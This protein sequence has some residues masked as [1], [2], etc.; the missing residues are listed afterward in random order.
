[1]ALDQKQVDKYIEELLDEEKIKRKQQVYADI[2]AKYWGD[3][4][5]KAKV[6][7]DPTS[8]LKA[9]GYD[10]PEGAR[11]KL[12]FNTTNRVHIVLPAPREYGG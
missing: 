3:P 1:M 12:V 7:A 11:V 8:V 10:I 6:D 5:F 9:E 4:D 2:L